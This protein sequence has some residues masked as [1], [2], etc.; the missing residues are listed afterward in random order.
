MTWAHVEI[1]LMSPDEQFRLSFAHL[2]SNAAASLCFL[3]FMF[4]YGFACDLAYISDY[5]K[6]PAEERVKRMFRSALLPVLGAW[7]CA[8]GWA[9]MCFDFPRDRSTVMK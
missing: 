2:I 8:F 7:I 6:R 1:T 5:N 3:G 9:Y 4:S